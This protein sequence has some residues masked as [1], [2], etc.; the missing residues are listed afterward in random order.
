[1]R[2]SPT[3]AVDLHVT[4]LDADLRFNEVGDDNVGKTENAIRLDRGYEGRD[5]LWKPLS[6]S[7]WAGGV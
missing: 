3:I 7:C 2:G 6:F 1:M 5:G 4:W